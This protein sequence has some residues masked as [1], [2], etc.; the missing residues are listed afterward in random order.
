VQLQKVTSS[1]GYK[2]AAGWTNLGWIY[3]NLDK[4]QESIAAYQ[5]ALELDPKQWQAALGLGWAQQYTKNYDK[6]IEATRRRSRST[7]RRRRA[8]PTSAWPGATSSSARSLRRGR[9]RT[10]RPLPA[11]T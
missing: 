8:T 1:P 2:D 4:A 9:R 5:K 10:R 7:R 3:R 11:A 6:A